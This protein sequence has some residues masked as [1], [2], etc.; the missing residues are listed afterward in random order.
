MFFYLISH[1]YMS[2]LK[3]PKQWCFKN[4]LQSVNLSV[5][6][7]LVDKYPSPHTCVL[8]GDA[9]LAIQEPEKA[10]E[11]YEAALKRNPHD[12][13]LAKKI[14]SALVK[15]HNYGKAINYYEASLHQGGVQTLR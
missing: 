4:L 8:L 2:V 3:Q 11:V 5:C 9:Y 15:T 14:G 12:P 6:R 7:E 13:I 10:I 1:C